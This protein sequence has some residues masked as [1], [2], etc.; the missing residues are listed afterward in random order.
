LSDDLVPGSKIT[1]TGKGQ[2]I[3][4]NFDTVVGG[5]AFYTIILSEVDT[6]TEGH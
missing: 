5:D 1:F 4:P 2:R 6:S 3:N